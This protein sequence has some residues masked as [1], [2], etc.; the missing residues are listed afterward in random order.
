MAPSP[1]GRERDERGLITVKTTTQQVH[2]SS[3]TRGFGL[4]WTNQPMRTRG[5][6][7]IAPVTRPDV[8]GSKGPILAEL[9]RAVRINNSND[10]RVALFV[11]G[12]RV[13]NLA[14]VDLIR[15][16]LTYYVDA[17]GMDVTV[18]SSEGEA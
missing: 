18:E 11:N 1:E 5:G 9:E 8:V 13:A 12:Q 15:E 7:V 2:V 16:F 6:L 14:R 10:W 17:E 4:G 3:R